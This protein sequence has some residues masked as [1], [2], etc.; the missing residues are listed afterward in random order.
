MQSTRKCALLLLLGAYLF[1]D[2]SINLSQLDTYGVV[3]FSEYRFKPLDRPPQASPVASFTLLQKGC[4]VSASNLSIPPSFTKPMA[5][6]LPS[7]RRSKWTVSLCIWTPLKPK[8]VLGRSCSKVRPTGAQLGQRSARHASA[9]QHAASA[10]CRARETP[11]EQCSTIG[12][13][14]RSASSPVRGSSPG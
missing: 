7:R 5:R 8:A 4:T 12:R 14:G 6:S 3:R 11:A 10:S 1:I 2:A 9:G 13:H